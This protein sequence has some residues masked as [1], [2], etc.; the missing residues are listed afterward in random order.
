V[1][2]KYVEKIKGF[3]PSK[4]FVGHMLSIGF[5]NYFI[6]TVLREEEKVNSENT[7][8]NNN[9]DLE[10]LLTSKYFYK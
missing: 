10:T 6:Q 4:I 1:S 3:D 2:L 8:V 7:H 5:S 9:V